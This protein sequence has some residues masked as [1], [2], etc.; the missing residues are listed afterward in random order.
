MFAFVFILVAVCDSGGAGRSFITHGG[1]SGAA[2]IGR[3][4]M[5]VIGADKG[6][7]ERELICALGAVIWAEKSKTA[8]F[9][10]FSGT[11][12]LYVSF[13]GA[14]WRK[15]PG[16]RDKKDLTEKRSFCAFFHVFS[17]FF[18]VTA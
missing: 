14:K 6:Y 3:L 5:A 16:K 17:A 4:D 11:E 10:Y 9:V 2:G 13:D 15:H 12:A 8:L 7:G 18:T 1:N